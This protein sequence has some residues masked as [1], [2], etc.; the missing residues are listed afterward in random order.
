MALPT[1]ISDTV[2]RLNPQLFGTTEQVQRVIKDTISAFTTPKKMIRQCQGDGL[3]RWER[4]YL[5]I[6]TATNPGASI[7]REVSLPLANGLRYKVDFL[8]AA[9]ATNG[10]KDRVSCVIGYEVKGHRKPTGIAKIK[11]AARVYPWITFKLVTK[12]GKRRGGGW[13]VERVLP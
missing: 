7:H 6:L 12:Q 1:Q 11:M 5:A 4:E 8:V 13:D 3:N 9:D 10:H 2:R